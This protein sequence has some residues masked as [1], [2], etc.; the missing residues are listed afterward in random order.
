MK[1]KG[2]VS[3][4]KAEQIRIMFKQGRSI[5]TI[6]RCL[7]MSRK[8]V[9]KML[10]NK[11]VDQCKMGSEKDETKEPEL[12][13]NK[14]GLPFWAN[15]LDI[16]YIL[17]ELKKGITYKILH[18]E[19]NPQVGYF[20]FW[21]TFKHIFSQKKQNIS[22]RLNHKPGEK[23]FVDFCD[24]IDIINDLT[25]EVITTELFVATFPFSQYTFAEFTLDQK[26]ETFIEVH[27]KAWKFFGG[28][29]EYTVPDNLKSAVTKSHRYDPDCNKTF[30]DYAN[31]AGFAVIPARPVKPRDKASV[32]G[33]IFHIQRSFFQ[34]VRHKKYATLF[35]LNHDLKEFLIEFNNSIMKDYGVSRRERFT[36]EE[37]LLKPLAQ[38]E[39]QLYFWKKAKVHPDCHIQVE[40]NFYSVPYVYVGKEVRVRY[41]K[42]FIEVFNEERELISNHKILKGIGKSSTNAEHWPKGKQEYLSFDISKGKS[43]AKKIGENTFFLV[44]FLFKQNH[45]LRYLRPVQGLLRLFYSNRFNKEDLEYATKMAMTHHI[46][47]LSYISDCCSFHSKG[48]IKPRPSNAPIRDPQTLHLHNV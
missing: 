22:M 19:L 42:R 32:E 44:D 38:E 37:A 13:I 36:T 45:P 28:V 16:D 23:V 40:K 12:E 33:N 34:K 1:R 24:G 26:L 11:V 48:G 27:E 21:R 17:K 47:R 25:G 9:R 30:C 41:S 10:Q 4:E 18:E 6:A 7:K 31:H 46:Y 29:P 14:E 2:K 8:T 15:D 5:R 20:G 39:F 35:D 3:M 43:E